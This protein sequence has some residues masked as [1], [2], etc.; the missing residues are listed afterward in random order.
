MADTR[1]YKTFKEGQTP[2]YWV[3]TI[4]TRFEIRITAAKY[5][6]LNAAQRQRHFELRADRHITK[7]HTG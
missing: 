5:Y 2:E 3:C 4:C 7:G 6:K 1:I